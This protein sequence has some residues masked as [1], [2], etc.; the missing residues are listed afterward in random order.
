ME[1]KKLIVLGGGPAG[2][3]VHD[4]AVA[5]GF[6]VVGFFDT[7]RPIGGTFRRLP[8][9]GS[10]DGPEF[11]SHATGR[12]VYPAIGD[13]AKRHEWA[14][15][16]A[17]AAGTVPTI[18]HPTAIVSMDA[19]LGT[20]AFVGAFSYVHGNVELG[21]SVLVESHVSIGNHSLIGEFVTIAQG[22]MLAARTRVGKGAY[23]GTA[24]CILPDV[25]VGAG[26]I[27]GAGAVVNRNVPPGSTV[28]GVPARPI[29][30]RTTQAR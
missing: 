24:A 12:N 1:T 9:L 8:I 17:R 6:E 19:E 14:G 13:T 15:R 28:A 4:A 30:G 2:Q 3:F 29:E 11:F 22:A 27:V 20:G 5:A 16:I 10:P 25:E 7:H 23:I 26:A 21:R 18:V